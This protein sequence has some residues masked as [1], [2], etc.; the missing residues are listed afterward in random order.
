MYRSLYKQIVGTLSWFPTLRLRRRY[1][2]QNCSFDA[3]SILTEL[4]N[5]A[6]QPHTPHQVFNANYV[7]CMAVCVCCTSASVGLCVRAD[8]QPLIRAARWQKTAVHPLIRS[9]RL[10]HTHIDTHTGENEASRVQLAQPSH[11]R[12]QWAFLWGS[13]LW[14]CEGGQNNE[15]K[16]KRQKLHESRIKFV[17]R[18]TNIVVW[19]ALRKFPSCKETVYFFKRWNVHRRGSCCFIRGHLMQWSAAL[20]LARV[21]GLLVEAFVLKKEAKEEDRDNMTC[22]TKGLESSRTHRFPY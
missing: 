13:A 17:R 19:K 5:D 20:I 7:S 11:R 15:W 14:E 1:T 4:Q 2:R 9:L 6:W 16:E 10:R 8:E 3:T 21:T 22:W 18:Q 12:G